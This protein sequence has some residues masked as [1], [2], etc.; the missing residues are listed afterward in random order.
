VTL[1]AR[2]Q[3]PE[4][5]H[6]V[7]ESLRA[8]NDTSSLNLFRQMRASR[9]AFTPSSLSVKLNTVMIPLSRAAVTCVVCHDVVGHGNFQDQ[10]E[11]IV[12][13]ISW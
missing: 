1:S 6:F 2:K 4:G 3:Q 10:D 5:S 8:S 7:T 12:I 13:S 11:R 9:K